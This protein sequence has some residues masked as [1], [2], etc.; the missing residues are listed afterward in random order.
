MIQRASSDL[1]KQQ[2]IIGYARTASDEQFEDTQQAELLAAGC[3]RI[4][5]ERPSH[6]SHGHPVLTRLLGELRAGDTLVVVRLDRLDLSPSSLLLLM[7]DFE[8]RGVHLRS[9]IDMIDTSPP[10][11]IACLSIVRALVQL[12]K[13]RGSEKT[14]AGIRAAKSR[15]KLAGNPGLRDRRPEA[16]QAASKA[17]DKNYLS[18]LVGSADVWLPTVK[19]LRPDHSWDNV[20]RVLNRRGMDWTVERLRRAVHRMARANLA[21]SSLL[22]RSPRRTPDDRLMTLI[23]AIA[24]AD[25]TLS[26]RGIGA[27]LELLGETPPRGGRKWQPSSVRHFLDE[28]RRFGLIRD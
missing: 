16:I 4:F 8:K 15:G 23:A 22:T 27:Q 14:K 21:D 17:R 12:E 24:I 13:R 6:P 7:E 26:L 1:L 20:V 19:K 11:G 9:I 5:D 2:R 25:P 28:A 3:E 10:H 18:Q